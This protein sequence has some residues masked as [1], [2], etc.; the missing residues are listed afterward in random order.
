MSNREN[1]KTVK[2]ITW[3]GTLTGVVFKV[4]WVL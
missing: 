1:N 2:T 4:K 3:F